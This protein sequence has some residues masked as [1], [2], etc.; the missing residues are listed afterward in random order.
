MVGGNTK[1]LPLVPQIARGCKFSLFL[2]IGS[3][4]DLT[5]SSGLHLC[6]IGVVLDHE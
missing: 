3:D 1:V 4:L 5:L 2:W 6:V